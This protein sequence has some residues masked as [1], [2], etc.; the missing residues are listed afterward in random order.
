MNENGQRIHNS[1]EIICNCHTY[2]MDQIAGERTRQEDDRCY[3]GCERRPNARPNVGP[4]GG[5]NIIIPKNWPPE[6][7]EIL[8]TLDPEQRA[9]IVD[10]INLSWQAGFFDG[11]GSLLMHR[12]N[13]PIVVSQDIECLQEYLN[14]HK[15]HISLQSKAGTPTYRN[16]NGKKIIVSKTTRDTHQ[17]TMTGKIKGPKSRSYI[18]KTKFLISILP[19]QHNQTKI[20]QVITTLLKLK[21]SGRERWEHLIPKIIENPSDITVDDKT[22]VEEFIETGEDAREKFR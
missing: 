19:L 7:R 3:C 12:A 15:G 8:D 2:G 5:G 11:E 14:R 20:E 1:R 16:I 21:W 13:I 6:I 17:W 18:D 4:R 22:I 10:F 9:K